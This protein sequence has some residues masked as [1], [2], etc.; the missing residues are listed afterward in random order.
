M[1]SRI[2]DNAYRTTV[3]CVDSYQNGEIAGRLYHPGLPEGK[4][5]LSLMQ[6][7]VEMEELLDELQFPQSFTA[8]RSFA[9]APFQLGAAIPE[10]LEERGQTATFSVRVLFRQ[11]TSWQG[12]VTWRDT[13]QEESFRSVLELVLL[14]HGALEQTT[15]AEQAEKPGTRYSVHP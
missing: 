14:M 7:L 2:R 9:P 15:Q 3:L 1:Q 10:D 12:A 8:R 11:N 5:F 4:Q 6:L 13:G